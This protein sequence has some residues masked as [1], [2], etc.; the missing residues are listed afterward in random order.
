MHWRWV[1]F[2]VII[3]LKQSV[4]PHNRVVLHIMHGDHPL[5]EMLSHTISTGNLAAIAMQCYP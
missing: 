5:G 1:I 2:P 3:K 4:D